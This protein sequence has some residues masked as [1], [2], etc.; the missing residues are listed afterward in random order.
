MREINLGFD[1]I[2]ETG[3]LLYITKWTTMN[4]TWVIGG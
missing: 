3:E 4:I 1:M 2:V